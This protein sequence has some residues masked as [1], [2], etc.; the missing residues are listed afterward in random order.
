MSKV[1]RVFLLLLIAG[2]FWNVYGDS[3]KQSGINGAYAEI[4]EDIKEIK[5]N[6]KVSSALTQFDRELRYIMR[7][8]EDTFEGNQLTDSDQ[9]APEKPDLDTPNQNSFSI[10][11]IEIG[12]TRT[13]VEQ[14][15]GEPKRSSMNEYGVNWVTYHENYHNFFMAT[16]NEENKVVGL[17]TNQ[18]LLS[19]KL[20]INF[21]STRSSVLETLDEPLQSIRK[22]FTRYKWQS[23]EEYDVFSIN[24]NYVTIFY[25]KHESNKV[26]A[27]QIISSEL[28]QKKEGFYPDPSAQLKKGFEYQLFDITNAARVKH[29]LPPLSWA[30][31]A[32]KTARAHSSDMAENNFF[33]HENPEGQSPFDRMNEDNISFITAGE[34]IAAGQLSSIYT[35]AG[36]MNSLGHRKNILNSKFELLAVGVAFNE[37]ARPYYTE[38]FLT[39]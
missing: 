6:P 17:Y 2:V 36:L 1:I 10:H 35:H 38:N 33:S 3:I 24:E 15:V 20:R 13:E 7:Q 29:D 21:T 23:N 19:S 9:P 4:Q 5:E 39:K 14:S 11:N 12:D 31:S 28:E 16:Y 22:G 8:I 34:N 25:D 26:T 27:I 18:D 30:D 32:R 37:D